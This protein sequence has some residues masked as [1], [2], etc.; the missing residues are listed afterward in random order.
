MIEDSIRA[1]KEGV[2]IRIHVHPGKSISAFPAGYDEWRKSITAHVKSDARENRANNE[3]I[4][5]VANFF[6][7]HKSS[8]KIIKGLTSRDKEIKIKDISM[9]EAIHKLEGA[10]R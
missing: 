2:V 1:C 6:D 9:K 4:F 7:V 8:I 3:I 5:L 10:L